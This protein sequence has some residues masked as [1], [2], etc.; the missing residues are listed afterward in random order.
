MIIFVILS[1]ENS[2]CDVNHVRLAIARVPNSSDVKPSL[3]FLRVESVDNVLDLF[4]T[5]NTAAL[6]MR[7]QLKKL[8]RVFYFGKSSVLGKSNPD[9]Y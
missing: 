3:E 7:Y 4:V 1:S 2:N 5:S 8:Q 6:N 9:R